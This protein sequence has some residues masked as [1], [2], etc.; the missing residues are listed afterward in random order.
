MS[1]Y[2]ELPVEVIEYYK[3]VE[4]LLDPLNVRLLSL[5]YK[6]GPGNLFT[7][8]RM[9]KENSKK[10]Y[11]RFKILRENV[12]IVV[13]ALPSITSIGLTNNFVGIKVDYRKISHLEDIFTG[14]KVPAKTYRVYG[15]IYNMFVQMLVPS[16]KRDVLDEVVEAVLQREDSSSTYVVERYC[17]SYTPQI[18]FSKLSL[19]FNPWKFDIHKIKDLMNEGRLKLV[20]KQDN[21]GL[22]KIDLKL[23]AELSRDAALSMSKIAAKIGISPAGLK[24]HFDKHVIKKRLIRSYYIYFPRYPPSASEIFFVKVNFPDTETTERFSYALSKTPYLHSI[25]KQIGKNSVLAL[26]EFHCMDVQKFLE[27][28]SKLCSE[29]VV[30]SFSFHHVDREHIYVQY[31]DPEL[32]DKKSGWLIPDDLGLAE[33][34]RDTITV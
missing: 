4:K 25:S 24:Y 9:L 7:I 14:L 16:E 17:E 26:I 6:Y 15:N 31:I 28:M 1:C 3:K 8:S 18:D 13:R 27:L 33:S 30:S 10:I 23:L 20:E 5:I 34:S 12:K 21:K 29:G 22:D 2:I 19:K 32:Y 11:Y